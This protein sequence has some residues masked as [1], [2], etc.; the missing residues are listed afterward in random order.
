M[1]TG[2][3]FQLQTMDNSLLELY[4]RGEISYDVALTNAREPAHIRQGTGN[5]SE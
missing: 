4:Q 1:Q 5:D 2:R 3:K